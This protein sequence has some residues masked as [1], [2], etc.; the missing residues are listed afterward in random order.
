MTVTGQHIAGTPTDLT[1]R[2][3]VIKAWFAETFDSPKEPTIKPATAPP[4]TSDSDADLLKWMRE[5]SVD[6]AE[7]RALFDEGDTSAFEGD[8]SKRTSPCAANSP[9]GPTTTRSA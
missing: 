5:S 2:D 1:E 4:A 8:H 3:D 6:G 9:T 7:F